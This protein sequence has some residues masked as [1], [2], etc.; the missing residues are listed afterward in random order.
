[1]RLQN[2]MNMTLKNVVKNII[3]NT[4]IV[5]VLLNFKK[6]ILT[7]LCFHGVTQYSRFGKTGNY[8]GRHIRKD[9]FAAILEYLLRYFHPISLGQ[10]EGFYYKKERLPDNPIFITFDDGFSNNYYHAFPVLKQFKCAAVIFVATGYI[11]NK[12]S[13]W[14]ER[15][16]YSILNTQLK[17]FK[18]AVLDEDFD[19]PLSTNSE[20]NIA[21]KTILQFL[22]AGFTFQKINESV[23]FICDYLGFHDLDVIGNNEDYRFLTWEEVKEMEGC[24]ISFGAHT[25]NHVNLIYEDIEK[26]EWEIKTSKID[27]EKHLG[28]ECI[29]FCYPFGRSGYNTKIEGLLKKAGFKF[30]F[31]LG[32]KLN[33][34]RTNPFLLNRISL[35]WESKKEDVMWHIL[36]K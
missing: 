10:L 17:N 13:F 25:V 27:I 35:G 4:P 28:K 29:G 11:D 8:E 19:L 23:N 32:G 18:M 30:S 15:L 21:Y 2:E 14:V 12:A 16:E 9:A 6:E 36:R 26:A 5:R 31:Q 22:K 20:R 1:M 3:L 33:D 24:G 7:I 34:R